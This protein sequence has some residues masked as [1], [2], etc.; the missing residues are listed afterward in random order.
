MSPKSLKSYVRAIIDD[1]RTL[2][3]ENDTE[4]RRRLEKIRHILAEAG[5]RS[6]TAPHST[7]HLTFFPCYLWRGGYD[8]GTIIDGEEA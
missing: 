7:V 5:K 4:F 2:I 3:E 8:H 1:I 6:E